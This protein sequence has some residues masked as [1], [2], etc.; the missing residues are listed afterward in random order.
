MY[1]II[2]E[3]KI[4]R[5]DNYDSGW[6]SFPTI[7]LFTDDGLKIDLHGRLCEAFDSGQIAFYYAISDERLS[8]E[9]IIESRLHHLYGKGETA[10]RVIEGCPT[11][12]PDCE[13]TLKIGGHNLFNIFSAGKYAFIKITFIEG[14]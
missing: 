8:E 4:L 10:R 1:D 14:D 3:G 9:E 12:G 2:L 11:C 13:S 6:G 5:E 7:K